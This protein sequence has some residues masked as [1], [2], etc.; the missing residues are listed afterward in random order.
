MED[1]PEIERIIITKKE[2]GFHFGI[3]NESGTTEIYFENSPHSRIRISN[4]ISHWMEKAIHCQ[5][6]V[7]GE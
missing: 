2:R 6:K 3:S 4:L 1:M 5:I 7:K